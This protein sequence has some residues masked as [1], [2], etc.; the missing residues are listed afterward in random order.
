MKTLQG[1]VAVITGG[2]TG[3]GRAICLKFAEE[4]ADVVIIAR[5]KS[6]IETVAEEVCDLGVRG[7]PITAD[8]KDAGR[9]QEVL[10]I[11]FE[12]FNK[13]DILVTSAGV[14]GERSLLVQTSDEGWR[15]TI[16]VNL[17]GVFYWVK[18]FAGK[19]IEQKSG[20]IITI[21]STSGK[22]PA[23]M[24]ADYSA[25]KYGVIGLTKALAIELGLLGLNGITANTICPG[26]INTDMMS[27]IV[28][29][30]RPLTGQ[31]TQEFIN[32]TVVNRS[33]QKRLLEPEEVADMALYL[34]SDKAK[35]I[36][37]QAINV[38]GGT[39]L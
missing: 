18:A 35:S 30:L 11:V 39:V 17:N 6:K 37:G 36:T 4:G 23:S 32:D 33:I 38:C 2:G 24:N 16:D 12:T 14:M 9:V 20:R 1:K 8:V 34:A 29:R 28:E 15:N 31:N 13:T 25:S 5:R 10:N 21:S 3:I 7:I 22:L 26:P 27:D 19:M